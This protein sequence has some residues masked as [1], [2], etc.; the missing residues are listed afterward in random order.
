VINIGTGES[1]AVPYKNH[2]NYAGPKPIIFFASG[3]GV[4]DGGQIDE[5]V[6]WKFVEKTEYGDL[7]LF[8]VTNKGKLVKAIPALYDGLSVFTYSVDDIRVK[9]EPHRGGE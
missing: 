8:A 1:K 2:S 3:F 9:I 6:S 4:N 5:E 7:Y